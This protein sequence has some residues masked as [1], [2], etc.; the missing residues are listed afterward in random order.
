MKQ[1][2]KGGESGLMS[3]TSEKESF[4]AEGRT[5]GEGQRPTKVKSE[6]AGKF[7]IK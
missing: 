7:T 2:K 6:K 1:E 3:G 5:P 4:K